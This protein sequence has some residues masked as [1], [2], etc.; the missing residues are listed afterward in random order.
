V[1]E[2][3]QLGPMMAAALA[4]HSM[5]WS[6]SAPEILATNGTLTEEGATFSVPLSDYLLDPGAEVHDYFVRFAV[7]PH[8]V[9][10]APP[11]PESLPP[12]PAPLPPETRELGGDEIHPV[13]P[14]DPEPVPR[15]FKVEIEGV[16]Q[17]AF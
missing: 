6:V 10:P 5:T 4:G 2:M 14:I 12:A 8:A 9:P 13:L 16:T 11:V 15:R 7:P 1:E 17:G 3:E